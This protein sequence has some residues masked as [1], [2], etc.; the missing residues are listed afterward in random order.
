MTI[1]RSSCLSEPPDCWNSVARQSSSSG[2]EGRA[3]IRPKSFGVETRPR[4]KC[5]CHARLTIDRQVS[6][7]RGSMI[8]RASLRGGPIR[9]ALRQVEPRI[10]PGQTAQRA[11]R[12]GLH[13]ESECHPRS[14]TLTPAAAPGG[15]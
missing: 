10:K 13:G 9:G 6:G 8:Q 15:L 11:G 2:C 12:G 14:S 4:P 5:C 1:S 7:L 3:P